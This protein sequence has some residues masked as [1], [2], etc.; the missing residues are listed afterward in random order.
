VKAKINSV[1]SITM[2]LVALVS[3]PA[4]ADTTNCLNPPAGLVGWW[5]GD[6][7]ANDLATNNHGTIQGGVTFVAGEVNLA[8]QFDGTTGYILVPD[9]PS[10]D[11]RSEA[12]F[13]AWINLSQLP[14]QAGHWM[15]IVGKSQAGNDLDLQVESDNRVHFYAPGLFVA[16]VHALQTNAWYFVAATYRATNRVEMFLNGV[17]EATNAIPGVHAVNP[18]PL[19]IGSSVV[20]PGRFFRG[21]IDEV[22]VYNRALSSNEIQAIYNAGGTGLCRPILCFPAIYPAV[23]IGWP[24]DT[25]RH[26][27]VQRTS[28]LATNNWVNLGAPITGTGSNVYLFDS[29]FGQAAR[30]YRVLNLPQ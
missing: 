30:F 9:N 14:S 7:D 28:A 15:F 18:N 8:F 12:T 26:Y 19:T 6:G 3:A 13:A 20:W 2:V 5:T 25:N 29:T 21:A 11:L 17:L 1:S 10:L 23:E 24:T 4:L 27:Q 22:Q 16:S